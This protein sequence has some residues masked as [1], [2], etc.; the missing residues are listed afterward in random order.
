MTSDPSSPRKRGEVGASETSTPAKPGGQL[1]K[2]FLKMLDDDKS[3]EKRQGWGKR[4]SEMIQ[5]PLPVS[6]L[7]DNAAIE[8][9]K[10]RGWGKRMFVVD[11]KGWGKRRNF[12]YDTN[13]DDKVQVIP[14]DYFEDEVNK[15]RGWGRR[16]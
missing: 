14:V 8:T 9:E 5:V 4:S 3:E 1:G 10:R 6:F 16:R 2:K 7:V 11:K 13:K 12:L 15:R